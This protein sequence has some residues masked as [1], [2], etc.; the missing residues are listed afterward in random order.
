MGRRA[1]TV[2]VVASLAA[3]PGCQGGVTS[4]AP[5]S[6]VTP[7]PATA[8]PV[9]P[10]E[11]TLS[12]SASL[13]VP[14]A[15]H[16]A[17]L[18]DDGRVLVVGGV[19]T[20]SQGPSPVDEAEV[21]DPLTNAF[22]RTTSLSGN[23]GYMLVPLPG[24]RSLPVARMYH[25]ATKLKDGRVLVAGGYG[26][27]RL[28]ENGK[29][30]QE[31]LRTAHVFDPRTNRFAVVQSPLSVPRS[32]HFAALLSNGRVLIAGGLCGRL[33]GGQGATV[34]AAEVFDPETGTFAPLSPAGQDMTVPRQEG[35]AVVA[36][37]KVLIVGGTALARLA[38]ATAPRPYF[39]PD[40]EVFDETSTRFLPTAGRPASDRR[41]QAGV[42]LA[43]GT[44][45]VVGGDSGKRPCGGV[46]AWD[47]AGG[48]FRP[49]G[50]LRFP[51]AR[52]AVAS[53][54]SRV[55][56]VG[57]TDLSEKDGH[58][59]ASVEVFSPAAGASTAWLDMAHARNGCTATRLPSG[60]VVLIVG[61]LEGGRDPL[62]LE[63]RAVAECER[64]TLDD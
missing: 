33:N 31:D 12:R 41:W 57:G 24:N 49:A 11:P 46:E 54:G 13:E 25:T 53:V 14:R 37:T 30:V 34:A 39:S 35:V 44:V 29:P 50:M 42:A 56:V 38:G 48:T 36:G 27:E 62:S 16:T 28:D 22:S 21:F 43:D 63:G 5:P 61:G 8:A 3:L 10:R 23:D 58:E 45:L 60:N 55:A 6:P 64:L 32:H 26:W 18:L 52:A 20:T 15:Y 2:A 9:P 59:L 1:L 17:T 7:G 19:T 40:A 51:R 47:P 4:G